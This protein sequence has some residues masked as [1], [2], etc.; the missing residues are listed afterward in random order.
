MIFRVYV[1]LPEGTMLVHASAFHV[2]LEPCLSHTS[3]CW[4]LFKAVRVHVQQ[5]QGTSFQG[6]AK[7]WWE[8]EY[9]TGGEGQQGRERTK[10]ERENIKPVFVFCVHLMSNDIAWLSGS[11]VVFFELSIV[12]DPLWSWLKNLHVWSC[13]WIFFHL[14]LCCLKHEKILIGGFNP[15]EKY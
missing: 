9:Q 6:K 11:N 7:T 15:S 12:W 3:A 10:T 2:S 5:V 13:L 8:G 1:Y 14:H 4:K